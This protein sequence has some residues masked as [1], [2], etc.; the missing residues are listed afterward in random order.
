MKKL[1]LIFMISNAVFA[2][3]NESKM[4]VYPGCEKF[5]DKENKQLTNCFSE[6]FSHEMNT[7]LN[8]VIGNKKVN[9]FGRMIFQIDENGQFINFNVD[10]NEVSKIYI[11]SAFEKHQQTFKKKKKKVL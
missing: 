9:V 11:L 4:M 3:S 6:K 1:L 8:K 2:Q 5:S 7:E 10:G